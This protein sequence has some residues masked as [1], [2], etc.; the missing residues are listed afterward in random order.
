MSWAR[1]GPGDEKEEKRAAP[2]KAGQ[3]TLF[4]SGTHSLPFQASTNTPNDGNLGTKK[5]IL[6]N[7]CL[8][9]AA[10][11]VFSDGWAGAQRC[12]HPC[13]WNGP[14]IEVPVLDT[15]QSRSCLTVRLWRTAREDPSTFRLVP[16]SPQ[17]AN[18]S[19]VR[20]LSAQSD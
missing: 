16:S 15:G 2:R 12:T 3:P 20:I 4:S 11:H 17:W 8:C 1:N 10:G 5:I 13:S 7:R 14:W 19:G 18:T 9:S 6:A